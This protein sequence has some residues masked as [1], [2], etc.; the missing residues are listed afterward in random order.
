RIVGL[1]PKRAEVILAGA[2]IVRTV[3]HKRRKAA[4]TVSA[5]GL[6]HGVLLERFGG[7]ARRRRSSSHGLRPPGP[8]CDTAGTARAT[9]PPAGCAD[10]RSGGRRDAGDSP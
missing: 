10:G 9:W 5:R 2:C 6:R 8:C 1:Q 3:L 4:L 7:D